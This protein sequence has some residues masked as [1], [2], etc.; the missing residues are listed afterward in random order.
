VFTGLIEDIGNIQRIA[1]RRSGMELFI[2]SGLPTAEIK[3]GDSIAVDGACL[4]VTSVQ[5]QGFCVDVS[6]ESLQR[7]T[8][9]KRRA[10]DRVNLERA[11]RL[12]DRL[13]GHLVSG[14]IDGLAVLSARE[15]SGEFN[16]LV[17]SA[18]EQLLKYIIEKGSVAIDGISLTVNTVTPRDFSVMI[19]PHTLEK[20]TLAGKGPG[21][22]VNIEN[23]IIGKYVEKLMEK[24]DVAPGGITLDF[25][26][27]HNFT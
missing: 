6:P 23:D 14:H 21:D 25:L 19:I 7:T 2:G 18:P 5:G 17:F 9:G 12:C 13:G 4:T 26:A 15:R 27:K 20:T 11:L 1:P 3:P 22:Q 10:G 24:H 8:L 16:R